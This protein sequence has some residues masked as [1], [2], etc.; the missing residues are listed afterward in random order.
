VGLDLLHRLHVD[1]W[2]DHCTRLEAVGDLHR[3]GGLGEALAEG[4]VDAVLHQ[5][6]I[7]PYAVPTGGAPKAIAPQTAT[8][9]ITGQF[10]HKP[11][12]RE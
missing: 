11:D 1:Q 8:S 3:T 4:V 9:I 2:A 12:I 5:D 10:P 7:G 6:A